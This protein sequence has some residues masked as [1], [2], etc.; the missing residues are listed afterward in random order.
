MRRLFLTRALCGL[1]FFS[2]LAVA[3][4]TT[5][6]RIES[7]RQ[8]GRGDSQNLP[9]LTQYLDDQDPSVRV[10]AVKAIV[11]I[12]TERSVDPLVK[13]THDNDANVDILATDGII[14]FY[15]PGYVSRGGLSGSVSKSVRQFKSFFSVRNRD[16][17]SPGILVRPPVQAALSSE[18]AHAPT[19][20]ARSN[21]ARAAG[22]LLAQETVPALEQALTS[23]ET[24]LILESLY[25]LQKIGDPAAGPSAGFLVHDLDN[26]VQLA[27]L[28]TVGVLRSLPSAPDV[29]TV[30][31]DARNQKIRRAAL[32]SLALLGIPGDRSLFQQ[33][34]SDSDASLRAAALE[35]LGRIREPKDYK[36]IEA[37][38]NEQNADWRVHLA[39][40]FAL[41]DEGKVD[42]TEFSPLQFLVENVDQPG[43]DDTAKAYLIELCRRE[44]VRKGV[45]ASLPTATAGQKIQIAGIL[46]TTRAA[47]AIQVLN[48][49]QNDPNADVSSA[50]AKG[51]RIAQA[52][53][54]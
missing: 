40:A 10:E 20:D 13:A 48:T 8:L 2:S 23:K 36:V 50:A 26:K 46:G 4:Q 47:D 51:L 38:F 54:P 9:S 27:A 30:V 15:L 49:M 11:K 25:S 39:A 14:N 5:K 43:R 28:E 41:V 1:W 53:R 12:G 31:A 19:I 29:R 35:G 44:D 16:E 33:Y 22:I 17:I 18:I 37:A 45:Y 6:Q 3:Q 32:Q 7:V 21:A 42:T 34:A 24:E 52:P